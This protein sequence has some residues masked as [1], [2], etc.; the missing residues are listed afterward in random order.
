MNDTLKKCP[1][2]GVEKSVDCFS[3]RTAAK[4]GKAPYCKDC[5]AIIDKEYHLKNRD[6]R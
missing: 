3:N 4:S 6:D 2:C 1:K 5:K